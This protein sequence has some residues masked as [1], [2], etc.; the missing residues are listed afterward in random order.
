MMKNTLDIKP[1]KKQIEE[2][3]E[4]RKQVMEILYK[5]FT[6]KEIEEYIFF[7]MMSGV[8]IYYGPKMTKDNMDIRDIYAGAILKDEIPP[9]DSD[10]M[11]KIFPKMPEIDY[12]FYTGTLKIDDL[13]MIYRKSDGEESIDFYIKDNEYFT[14]IKFT[15]S[16]RRELTWTFYKD[17]K[18]K[19]QFIAFAMNTLRQMRNV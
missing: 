18:E 9:A 5:R 12:V 4:M 14:S 15:Y 11:F 2:Q 13:A 17:D 1:Y 3:K 19:E 6:E 8:G 7:P 10:N 16:I